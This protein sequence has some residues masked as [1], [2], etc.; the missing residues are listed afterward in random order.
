MTPTADQTEQ[1]KMAQRSQRKLAQG[2]QMY[3]YFIATGSQIDEALTKM[4]AAMDA[5]TDYEDRHGRMA[6]TMG[7][8]QAQIEQEDNS[9]LYA[10][11][12]R[13]IIGASRDMARSLG[14]GLARELPHLTG[15]ALGARVGHLVMEC[16]QTGAAMMLKMLHGD[17]EPEP[18][19]EEY[20]HESRLHMLL[21]KY[22]LLDP[23]VEN[24][25]ALAS[26]DPPGQSNG[27]DPE[28]EDWLCRSP[29]IFSGG[30]PQ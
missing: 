27:G 18:W 23:P 25:R 12:P 20:D 1:M 28:A 4:E 3:T 22:G 2:F 5:W 24:R 30:S 14:V 21:D 11:H 10:I 19:A 16:L 13:D 6:D 9:H 8:R 15:R 7:Q 26:T 29:Q 17:I